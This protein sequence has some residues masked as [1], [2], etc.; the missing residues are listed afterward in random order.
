MGQNR[1]FGAVVAMYET[2]SAEYARPEVRVRHILLPYVAL[3]QTLLAQLT[4]KK[5]R[6]RAD[7]AEFAEEH[8]SDSGS[9]MSGGEL[10][11][12]ADG[13]MVKEFSE[14]SFAAEV[15]NLV[16]P[17]EARF[18]F[19]TIEVLNKRVAVPLTLAA[20]KARMDCKWVT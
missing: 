14:A 20:V 11:W 19:H 8:S 5:K 16:G 9:N 1:P 18:G 3:A 12:F 4:D 15:G 6:R 7:F 2:R 13:R 17:I 10:G